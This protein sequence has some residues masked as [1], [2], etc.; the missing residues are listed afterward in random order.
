MRPDRNGRR[1]GKLGG[2]EAS[3]NDAA[4][5]GR[6]LIGFMSRVSPPSAPGCVKRPP[7]RTGAKAFWGTPVVRDRAC[8]VLWRPGGK[9]ASLSPCGRG[10]FARR[11]SEREPGEGV[12]AS[13]SSDPTPGHCYARTILSHRGERVASCRT[14]LPGLTRPPSLNSLPKHQAGRGLRPGWRYKKGRRAALAGGPGSS[15]T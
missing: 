15:R 7:P 8:G 2:R 14:A 3:E 9:L 11:E 10:W 4:T 6:A 5:P 12:C 13:R 1:A